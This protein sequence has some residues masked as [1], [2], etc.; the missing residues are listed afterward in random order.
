MAILN[1]ATKMIDMFN[2]ILLYLFKYEFYFL[3]FYQL[4][5]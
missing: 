1:L 5:V 4:Y 2:L 3:G